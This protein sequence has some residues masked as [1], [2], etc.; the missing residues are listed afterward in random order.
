MYHVNEIVSYE[1]LRPM[2]KQQEVHQWK[3]ILI[4]ILYD[5]LF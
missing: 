5:R 3:M 1:F 4:N 2:K